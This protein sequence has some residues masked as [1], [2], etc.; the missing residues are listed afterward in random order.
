MLA[1]SLKWRS[2]AKRK[3][4]EKKI[5]LYCVFPFENCFLRSAICSLWVLFMRVVWAPAVSGLAWGPQATRL[6]PEEVEVKGCPP[7]PSLPKTPS[8]GVVLEK[9][10]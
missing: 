5:S 7:R 6:G 1:R 10:I 2:W 8:L 4:G 3:L 9:G